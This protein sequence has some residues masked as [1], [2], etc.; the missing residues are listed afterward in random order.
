MRDIRTLATDV[1]HIIPFM[2]IEDPN[3]LDPR[4]LRS[5]CRSC[6]MRHHAHGVSHHQA[7]AAENRPGLGFSRG[8]DDA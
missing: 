8:Q 7:S 1:D 3:R 5:L 4:N 2:S 6:H